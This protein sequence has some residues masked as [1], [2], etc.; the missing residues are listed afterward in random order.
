MPRTVVL[1]VVG[2]TSSLLGTP[3]TPNLNALAS[4]CL[5]V[6]AIT[7]ALTCSVQSTYLTGKLPSQHGIVG[8][9][10]YSRELGEVLFWRQSNRLVQG[11][12]LWHE[13]R[14]RNPAFTAANTFWW[15][16][17]NGEADWTITPRPLYLA[18]G[19]KLPDVWT[20]PLELRDEL[21]ARLGTFPLF[22]F[23]GPRANVVSSEWIARAAGHVSATR[24]PTLS[25]VYL[26]HLDYCLQKLGPS[27]P[28]IV[29]HLREVDAQTHVGQQR[30][31]REHR[32]LQVGHGWQRDI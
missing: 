24:K 19:R 20:D 12:K 10:W 3:R 9:G 6:R 16:A 1:N 27:N 11:D 14:R 15:Y 25:L 29:P 28:E 23:W 21:T 22:N 18:D 31:R 32:Q 8:N 2:L 30:L 13:G 4:G 17:M 5:P 7:P 26:P